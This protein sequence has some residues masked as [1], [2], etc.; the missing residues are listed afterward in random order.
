MRQ[1]SHKL[2]KRRIFLFGSTPQFRLEQRATIIFSFFV[3]F[4]TAM[5]LQQLFF[6]MSK[7]VSGNLLS[8]PS[9]LRAMLPTSG[10]KERHIKYSIGH[11]LKKNE[12]G[13]LPNEV[14]RDCVR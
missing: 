13:K 4:N 1:V 5:T 14:E 11:P 8:I 7:N 12:Y 2:D 6:V 3:S 10:K 9:T